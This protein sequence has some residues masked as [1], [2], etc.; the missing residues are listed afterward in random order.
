M[1]QENNSLELIFSVTRDALN[2]QEEQRKFLENK[3]NML[4]LFAGG[5]FALLMNSWST[6]NRFVLVSQITLLTGVS[7]FA[8]SVIFAIAATWVRKHHF[9]PNPKEL[10]EHFLNSPQQVTKLQLISNWAET[11]QEQLQ[12]LER[13]TYFL[14]L[15]FL[16]QAVGFLLL[17]LALFLSVFAKT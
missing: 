12:M 1:E 6:I 8:F 2:A 9:V 3:A 15:T 16:A 4:L 11:W 17:G 13:T 10:S 5:I 14:R 7:F